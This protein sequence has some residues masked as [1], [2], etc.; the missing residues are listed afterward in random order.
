MKLWPDHGN[1]NIVREACHG[2]GGTKSAGLIVL[3]RKTACS[4]PQYEVVAHSLRATGKSWQDVH[5][6]PAA[7]SMLVA[8]AVTPC[9]SRRLSGSLGATLNREIGFVSSSFSFR[10]CRAYRACGR[11]EAAWGRFGW[12]CSWLMTHG[13]WFM[14]NGSCMFRFLFVFG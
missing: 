13:S 1:H 8:I 12:G 14:A 7:A 5:Q 6:P 2:A 9:C 4:A 11:G 3:W 10:A